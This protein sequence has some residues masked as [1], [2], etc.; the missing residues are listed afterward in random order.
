MII[1]IHYH[2]MPQMSESAAE[3]LAKHALKAATMMGKDFEFEA[4]KKKALETWADPTGERLIASMEE[5]G[6]DLSVICIVDN[7]GIEQ[8]TVELIQRANKTAGEIAKKYPDKVIALAGIDPRRPQ[9]VDMMKQ[10]FQEFGVR[11]LKY[12]PDYGYDPV[13]PESYRVLEVLAENNGILLTHT[14][15][16]APPSRYKYADPILLADIG[17][18]FPELKVVAA[19]MGAVNWRHW[20]GLAVHQPNLYGDLAMW[21]A[22][23]FGNYGFFCRELRDILD[24]A[25]ASKVLFGT[26]NPI[27]NTIMPTREWVQ[28]IK[29]LPSNAPEGIVFTDQEVAAILGEN[30][31]SILG[32]E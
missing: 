25:G 30:A 31:S 23:A 14:G 3:R 8:A 20:A 10:C 4:I 15:P 29:D 6:I 28:L 26:D 12:H 9:A 11:G 1:D 7:A 5:S 2:L 32:L 24:Y 27:Y 19:H 16:L 18:D 21:D 22:Y 17:V 13:G